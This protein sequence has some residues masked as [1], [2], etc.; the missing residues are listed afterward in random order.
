[1]VRDK[2][3][4]KNAILN[5]HVMV[6]FTDNTVRRADCF[7]KSD[8]LFGDI[9]NSHSEDE[10]DWVSIQ[11]ALNA[12][13]GV[14]V[15]VA[16][17][18]SHMKEKE[19]KKARPKF[20]LYFPVPEISSL[21]EY[22]SYLR[23][24][25]STYSHLHLDK[26]CKDAPRHFGATIADCE[27]HVQQGK[28]LTEVLPKVEVDKDDE[29]TT[30]AVEEVKT[31]PQKSGLPLFDQLAGTRDGAGRR[32]ALYKLACSGK[33][34]GLDLHLITEQCQRLNAT[35]VPPLPREDVLSQ[36][37]HCWNNTKIS[38]GTPSTEAPK[39]VTAS[40]GK[41]SD[42]ELD[43]SVLFSTSDFMDWFKRE[44]NLKATSSGYSITV[45]N[46]T[47]QIARL[48][49]NLIV[50]YHELR[51]RFGQSLLGEYKVWSK[52]LSVFSAS[53]EDE[54]EIASWKKKNPAPPKTLKALCNF[55]NMELISTQT[56]TSFG[57]QYEVKHPEH[58]LEQVKK[59][60]K[61]EGDYQ[62]EE[63]AF[64]ESLNLTHHEVK[65][66]SKWVQNMKR[67]VLGHNTGVE[68]ALLLS[69][70][71]QGTGK[72]MFPQFLLSSMKPTIKNI[73]PDA[74][75]DKNVLAWSASTPVF[76]IDEFKISERSDLETL[77]RIITSKQMDHRPLYSRNSLTLTP[78][79]SFFCS[80]NYELSDL[81]IDTENRR[82]Y[83]IPWSSSRLGGR[84][85]PKV[86]EYYKSVNWTAYLESV[87]V[88]EDVW[89][90]EM[91]DHFQ[92]QSKK[93]VKAD[94]LL[95]F[96]RVHADDLRNKAN[97]DGP[98]WIQTQTLMFTYNEYRKQLGLRPVGFKILKNDMTILD[99][100]QEKR[101]RS[102]ISCYWIGDILKAND[103][104]AAFLEE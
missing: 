23:N 50:A 54:E 3:S 65:A 38:K 91:Y 1:M 80:S 9:D 33:A 77:K 42:M 25:I 27:I 79:A 96:I 94:E 70:K 62:K 52:Q 55:L 53:T 98:G 58:W 88:D 21:V 84:I 24:L 34:R 60:I 103:A 39:M 76:I 47:D 89:D 48:S 31:R 6:T 7:V 75:S 64:R 66:V 87:P 14:E 72:S 2:V 78:V 29:F 101:T 43:F 85:G 20:H 97:A 69:S 92:D 10:N 4:F 19:G 44:Y 67:R 90:S 61:V 40:I 71:E 82:F 59:Y 15:W 100:P 5:D 32:D 74:L 41:K 46:E 83:E 93:N 57:N 56:L 16:T 36:V 102:Q 51:N 68:F 73:Q 81:I 30:F 63:K 95:D 49:D 11:E 13:P 45:G 18:K 35:F 28:P 99:C 17:S 86:Y 8:V 104:E 37:N 12:F 26:A 22:E